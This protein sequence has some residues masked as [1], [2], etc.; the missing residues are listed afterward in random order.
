MSAGCDGEWI[1]LGEERI[2]PD[3]SVWHNS[4]PCARVGAD[5][6][7]ETDHLYTRFMHSVSNVPALPL[8][9]D[10]MK[11]IDNIGYRISQ[12]PQGSPRNKIAEYFD[13]LQI[14]VAKAQKEKTQS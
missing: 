4:Y 2:Y 6:K 12:M 1:V 3:K 11:A 7:I 9:P 5:D 13:G 10:I 8:T 14:S